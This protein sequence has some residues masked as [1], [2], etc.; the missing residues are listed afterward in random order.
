[1]LLIADHAHKNIA[2]EHHFMAALALM[3][4]LI[5]QDELL[6]VA[7]WGPAP[8]YTSHCLYLIRSPLPLMCVYTVCVCT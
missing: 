8:L 4:H 1:M 7:A 5:G 2:C 6:A 3:Q